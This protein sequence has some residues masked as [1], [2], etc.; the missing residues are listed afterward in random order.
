[1]GQLK[2]LKNL[3]EHQINQSEQKKSKIV[4]LVPYKRKGAKSSYGGYLIEFAGSTQN[5]TKIIETPNLPIKSKR[6]FPKKK[7]YLVP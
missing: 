2:I 7:G 5:V 3:S 6:Y 4:C 1:M